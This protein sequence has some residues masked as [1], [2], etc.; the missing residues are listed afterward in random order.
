MNFAEFAAKDNLKVNWIAL[1]EGMGYTTL[2]NNTPAFEYFDNGMEDD[3]IIIPSI[4][5]NT[6]AILAYK[7]SKDLSSVNSFLK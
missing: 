7:S 5:K 3:F 6:I 1:E 2:A 4:P